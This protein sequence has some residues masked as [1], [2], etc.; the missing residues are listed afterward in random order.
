VKKR[1]LITSR[2]TPARNVMLADPQQAL[3]LFLQAL[4]EM[5]IEVQSNMIKAG[6]IPSTEKPPTIVISF[7]VLGIPAPNAQEKANGS[8]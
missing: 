8:T 7:D 4:S 2:S 1:L 5:Q 6:F 3:V